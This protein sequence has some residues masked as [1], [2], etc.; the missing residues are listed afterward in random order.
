MND[1]FH[2]IVFELTAED[3]YPPVSAES[4]W[5][6]QEGENTYKMDNTPY[7]VFGVSQGDWIL[8]RGGDGELIAVSVIKQGGH[9]T[10]RVF[11]SDQKEKSEII[12][13]L[14]QMGAGCSSTPELSLFTVD[15]PTGCDF[16]EVDEYLSSIANGDN[17]AYEDAC[18][19]H[20][21][22]DAARR[23]ECS[24]LASIRIVTH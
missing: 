6:N 9:S 16:F 18:L 14:Q 3:D 7:Y 21:E 13:K 19:Q 5:G 20:Q 12:D 8:A 24:S 23:A 15:I 10:V 1:R 11:A 2:K 17:I 22:I 4:L